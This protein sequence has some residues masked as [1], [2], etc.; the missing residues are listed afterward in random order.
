L[1]SPHLRR[2][3]NRVKKIASGNGNKETKIYEEREKKLVGKIERK[4]TKNKWI[5]ASN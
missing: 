2:I 4:I 3:T 1:L 5:D